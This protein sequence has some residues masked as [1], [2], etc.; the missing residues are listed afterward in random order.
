MVQISLGAGG[1]KQGHKGMSKML[2]PQGSRTSRSAGTTQ[3]LGV[4]LAR[5]LLATEKE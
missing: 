4:F 1:G 5:Y 3:H 2:G